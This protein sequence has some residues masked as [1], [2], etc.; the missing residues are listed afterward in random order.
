[1]GVFNNKVES[2]AP[3]LNKVV[4]IKAKS[5]LYGLYFTRS[6]EQHINHVMQTICAKDLYK[7]DDFQMV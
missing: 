3:A 2:E 4:N 1:M 5:L 6:S 7:M